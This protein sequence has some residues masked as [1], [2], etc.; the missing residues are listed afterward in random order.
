MAYLSV[1]AFASHQKK[2][3]HPGRLVGAD[4]K[5][6]VVLRAKQFPRSEAK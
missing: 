3:R 5:R 1:E 2:N 6:S 4:T